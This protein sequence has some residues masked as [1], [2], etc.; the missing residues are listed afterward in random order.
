[1]IYITCI[2]V[3]SLFYHLT[4]IAEPNSTTSGSWSQKSY[5]KTNSN[6]KTKEIVTAKPLK[7][8]K[9][10]NQNATVIHNLSPEKGF[11]V[12]QGN[13]VKVT[14]EDGK[15]SGWALSSDVQDNINTSYE[16]EYKIIINGPSEH[17]KVSKI[18]PKILHAE[19]EELKKQYAEAREVRRKNWEKLHQNLHIGDLWLQHFFA[20][21]NIGLSEEEVYNLQTQV[22]QLQ[23][24]VQ[25]LK[26]IKSENLT[27]KNPDP[28]K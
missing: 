20:E 9:E 11:E 23:K 7:I 2:I 18:S 10:P 8:Y 28:S 25:Q 15:I 21:D 13:W 26:S 5:Y 12:Q 6:D 4:S 24:E 19:Q 17:Y 22:N 16:Q 27:N 3:T 14:T 1:M